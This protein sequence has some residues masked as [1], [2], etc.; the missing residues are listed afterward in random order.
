MH[1][2]V[3]NFVCG[4]SSACRFNG[5]ATQY[6]GTTPVCAVIPI[7]ECEWNWFSC[8]VHATPIERQISVQICARAAYRLLSHSP[9]PPSTLCINVEACCGH[10]VRVAF[11]H[12]MTTE[13]NHKIQF[14]LRTT[15]YSTALFSLSI[16]H[17]IE[18]AGIWQPLINA[19]NS[20]IALTHF[21][22]PPLTGGLFSFLVNHKRAIPIDRNRLKFN[23]SRVFHIV[24]EKLDWCTKHV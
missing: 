19:N 22:C 21:A 12:V 18:L 4:L 17:S 14:S 15:N 6:R 23:V 20:I 13:Q 11:L 8:V 16:F 24:S 10:V 3:Y 5:G 1:L 2:R 7:Q 9:C